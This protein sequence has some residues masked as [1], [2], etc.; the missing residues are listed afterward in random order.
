[1]QSVNTTDCIKIPPFRVGKKTQI[2]SSSVRLLS[3][4]RYVFCMFLQPIMPKKYLKDRLYSKCP[5]KTD[6]K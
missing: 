5:K 2:S 3:I 1:M 4:R 6:W